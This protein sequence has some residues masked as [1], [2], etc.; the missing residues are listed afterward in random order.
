MESLDERYFTEDYD[1]VSDILPE[2]DIDIDFSLPLAERLRKAFGSTNKEV[3]AEDLQL[4]PPPSFF[5][6]NGDAV[7]SD[8]HD[9]L[10]S[11]RVNPDNHILEHHLHK[12][13]QLQRAVERVLS[14]RILAHSG[15]FLAGLTQVR[16]AH[17]SSCCTL[18]SPFASY[19]HT[20]SF[21]IHR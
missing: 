17:D 21:H 3:H 7:A 6:E 10:G 9:M 18:C 20:P 12:L 15:Q 5:E 14:A 2:I 4:P 11:P 8:I 1:P 16:C 13:E 19:I